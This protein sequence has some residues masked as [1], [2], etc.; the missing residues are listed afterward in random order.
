MHVGELG[1]P[2]RKLDRLGL[3]GVVVSP[4]H[5]HTVNTN[6]N[7]HKRTAHKQKAPTLFRGR[8]HYPLPGTAAVHLEL[9]NKNLISLTQQTH[10]L[11][12]QRTQRKR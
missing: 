4:K 2:L 7:T 8:Y 5:S 11:A 12:A 9:L 3:G 10:T 6:T 1:E